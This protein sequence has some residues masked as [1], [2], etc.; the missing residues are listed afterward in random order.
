MNNL[1]SIPVFGDKLVRKTYIE[2]PGAYAVIRNARQRIATLRAGA[3]FFLPGGGSAPGEIPKVTLHR[4]IL[5]ECGC[6]IEIGP[7]LGKAIEYIYARNEGLHYLIHSTFFEAMFI[8]RQVEQP[9]D[10]LMLVWLAVS[11]AVQR[12]QRQSQAWAVQQLVSRTA[13]FPDGS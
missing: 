11:E 12:L 5:E 4:E 6:A 8:D 1:S 2:R 3:G 13:A 7:E 9:E 10:N